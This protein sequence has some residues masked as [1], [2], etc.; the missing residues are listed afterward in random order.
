MPGVCL[1]LDG[2]ELDKHGIGSLPPLGTMPGQRPLER[3]ILALNHVRHSGGILAMVVAETTEQAKDAIE[4]ISV[5]ITPLEACV[6]LQEG[7]CAYEWQYGDQEAVEAAFSRC[8]HVVEISA[9][10]NRV[11]AQSMETRTCRAE[12]HQAT[13]VHTLHCSSQGA[14]KIRDGIAE[15][16]LRM[17]REQLQVITEDVGGAFGMKLHNYPEYALTLLAARLSGK[18]VYWMGGSPR[19]VTIGRSWQGPISKCSAWP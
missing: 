17:P 9:S 3:P 2:S 10:S 1:V 5:S 6:S 13:G 15:H 8:R 18:P 14:H 16:V 12:V 7:D 19:S 4:Q 11:L